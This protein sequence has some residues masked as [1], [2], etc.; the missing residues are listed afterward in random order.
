MARKSANKGFE[1]VTGHGVKS[2]L[3]PIKVPF[4]I[5]LIHRPK[6]KYKGKK[7]ISFPS[8]V[9][10]NYEDREK[11]KE[12]FEKDN[13]DQEFL[14]IEQTVFQMTGLCPK[15]KKNG[16]P[17]IQKDNTEAKRY[18]VTKRESK[19]YS[20]RPTYWLV[21]THRGHPNCR[22]RQWQGN[23]KGTFKEQ[24]KIKPIDPRLFMLGGQVQELDKLRN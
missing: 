19:T 10:A 5:T 14:G 17:S 2:K 13:P 7:F 20:Y 18:N 23:L 4:P 21:Y 24:K 1:F 3:Y 15:C 6:G 8:P 9:Y 12:L 16:V 11:I 22:V